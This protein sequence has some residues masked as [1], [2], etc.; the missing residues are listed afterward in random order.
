[1]MNKFKFLFLALFLAACFVGTASAATI[2]D[3]AASTTY[4]PF[5][6]AYEVYD[7]GLGINANQVPIF[8]VTNAVINPGDN[9]NLRV[10][11]VDGTSNG[12]VNPG[13]NNVFLTALGSAFNSLT[14]NCPTA[15]APATRYIFAESNTSSDP[16][17]NV[18]INTY[19]NAT[20]CQR[21]NLNGV[22]PA[23][24]TTFTV[25]PT[26]IGGS[27]GSIDPLTGVASQT[28]VDRLNFNVN[29]G[30][31]PTCTKNPIVQLAAIF[32]TET[33]QPTTIL[34]ITPQFTGTQTTTA[35]DAELDTDFDF[36]RFIVSGNTPN[37]ATAFSI[38]ASATPPGV[39]NA[40]TNPFGFGIRAFLI[41]NEQQIAPIQWK[42]FIPPT[43][44]GSISFVLRSANPEPGLTVQL[45]N[46][47]LTPDVVT[48]T[49]NT[50]NTTWT[51]TTP[52]VSS[53]G[54]WLISS[55]AWTPGFTDILITK[56][57]ATSE[58]LPTIW[59]ID[60]GATIT[61]A[62]GLV[63]TACFSPKDQVGSWFGGLEAFVPFVKSG[64]GYD[65]TIKLFN[66][67]SK[68]AK[69]FVKTFKNADLT[70]ATGRMLISTQQL[71]PPNDVIKTNDMVV[72]T[73]ADIATLIPGYDMSKGIP[74][75]FL[76]RVPSQMGSTQLNAATG[77]ITHSNNLDP[78]VEGI[79][80]STF[81]TGQR[82]IPLKFKSFKNG[83]YDH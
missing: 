62:G 75:K 18:S 51:C 8:I 69:L 73:A 1:M 48:C 68:D 52:A 66:R 49:A 16:Q 78:F 3:G 6:I 21:N 76:I 33:A 71:P 11:N 47:N 32:A 64:S 42:A 79:V 36:M 70:A 22:G 35:L 31:A 2:V 20:F 27:L 28:Q 50:D 77:A 12:K 63:Q 37:V 55:F 44:K 60:A 24:T 7:N 59:T 14:T 74:V 61:V 46:G 29:P 39:Y 56:T 43:Q 67:Y 72:I 4:T 10:V 80:V 19:N 45:R 13:G 26:T 65:T 83:E 53:A 57:T 58:L 41:R 17:P 25:N 30:L 54:A 81:S 38:I 15:L 9:I 40:V 23:P 5:K 82:T 34:I